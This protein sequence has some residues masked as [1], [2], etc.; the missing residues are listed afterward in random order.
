MQKHNKVVEITG[1]KISGQEINVDSLLY[2][3]K[4]VLLKPD[5]NFLTLEF[6][7]HSYAGIAGNIFY[8]L[9]GIDKNWVK[10]NEKGIANYA[11]LEPGDYNFTIKAGED[12]SSPVTSLHIVIIPPFYSTWWFKIA[13][14]LLAAF[15]IYLF[16]R[17]RIQ[18]IRYKAELRH[19]ISET[20][21]LALPLADE[22]SFY[23]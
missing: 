5:Q 10:A 2:G 13:M 22:P 8:K 19:K 18:N 15:I 16:V 7:T 11:N 9:S 1:F 3:N 20:E 14:I 17:R 21:M 23:F 12:I 6:T 4:T